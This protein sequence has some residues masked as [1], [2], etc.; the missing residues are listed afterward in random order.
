MVMVSSQCDEENIDQEFHTFPPLSLQIIYIGIF[1][2]RRIS[3]G[4]KEPQDTYHIHHGSFSFFFSHDKNDLL[5]HF[6]LN[7]LKWIPNMRPKRGK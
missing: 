2:V 4:Y 1:V 3:E 5:Y 6:L 7:R